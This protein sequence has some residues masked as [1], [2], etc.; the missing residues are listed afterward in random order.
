LF[1]REWLDQLLVGGL[2][3]ASLPEY[4]VLV[5]VLIGLLGAVGGSEFI[6]LALKEGVLLLLLDEL[7]ESV[8][9]GKAVHLKV[10]GRQVDSWELL[11]NRLTHPQDT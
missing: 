2:E 10:V 11:R 8:I 6:I 7:N 4:L 3:L 5:L 1:G 9:F